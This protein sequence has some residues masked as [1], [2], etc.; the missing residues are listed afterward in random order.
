MGKLFNTWVGIYLLS[1]VAVNVLFSYVPL[2]HTPYG[3]VSLVALLVG[4]A[5]VFRDYAQRAAGHYVIIAMAVG[6]AISYI[7]AD[8]FVAIAS[9]LAF[10]SSEIIDWLFYTFAKLPFN[11]RVLISSVASTPV[12]TAVFLLMIN[13]MTVGTFVLMVLSKLVAAVFIYYY[14]APKEPSYA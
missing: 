7:M 12:D 14:A 9:V 3:T 13:Q 8:P 6:A 5:F 11:K 1:I 2:I 10:A 4:F